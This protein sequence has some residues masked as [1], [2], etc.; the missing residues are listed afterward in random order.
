MFSTAG[1]SRK[2]KRTSIRNWTSFLLKDEIES[3]EEDSFNTDNSD[4]FEY[5]DDYGYYRLLRTGYRAYY[6]LIDGL[7][8]KYYDNDGYYSLEYNYHTHSFY[9]QR[10]NKNDDVEKYHHLSAKSDIKNNNH[11]LHYHLYDNSD[12]D[13]K[14]ANTVI[15]KYAYNRCKRF[16][17]YKALEYLKCYDDNCNKHICEVKVS[18]A[19]VV[20]N[21]IERQ[22]KSDEEKRKA[23]L[24]DSKAKAMYAR[25]KLAAERKEAKR[26]SEELED[27]YKELEYARKR[28]ERLLSKI[29]RMEAQK[30]EGRKKL[31]MLHTTV[32]EYKTNVV[33]MENVIDTLQRHKPPYLLV[34]GKVVKNE[35][36]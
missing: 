7:F 15:S 35:L 5:Y 36:L 10:E 6:E 17:F 24:R 26:V 34:N 1:Y 33:K 2:Q 22:K 11:G 27:V 20:S 28:E 21:Q 14:Y 9:K 19:N 16:D 3:R 30:R 8:V 32:N 4:D 13:A 25:E 12:Y 18:Y 29:E 23:N 31:W